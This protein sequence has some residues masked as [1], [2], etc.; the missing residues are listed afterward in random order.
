MNARFLI[1]L[2]D[3]IN[4]AFEDVDSS[5]MFAGLL[6]LEAQEQFRA[7]SRLDK[8]RSGRTWMGWCAANVK[9]SY[10]D[11]KKC[12]ALARAAEPAAAVKAERARNREAQQRKKLRG[13]DSEPRRDETTLARV[14]NDGR[15]HGRGSDWGTPQDLYDKLNSEFGFT[16]DVC[17]SEANA[18]H[19]NYFTKQRD[20]LLQDWGQNVCF[21][22]ASWGA[23]LYESV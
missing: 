7:L 8:M 18:K 19:P 4:D 11:I 14:R 16:L 17:A 15:W 6:L 3:Q 22:N 10:S 9:R 12:M 13:S 5:R 21:C 20:G 2:A 1:D 23:G